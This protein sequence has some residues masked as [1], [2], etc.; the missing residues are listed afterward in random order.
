MSKNIG[1]FEILSELARSEFGCVYK[2]NDPD[3]GQ[4]VALKTIRLD[5]F[6]EHAQELVQRILKE[7][8]STKDLDCSNITLVYGAGEIDGQLCAT[9]DYIQGNS[10]ATMLARKEGFSIWDLLDISNQVCQGL[11]HAHQHTVFHYSL[12]PA[13]IMVT[14]DGTVKILSFGISSTGFMTAVAAGTPPSPLY[15]MSPEQV[16][17]ETMDPRSNLFTWGAMLYEMVTDQKAFDGADADEVRRKILEEMPPAPAD[18]NPKIN[19]IASEVIMKALA[20]DPAQRY[21]SGREM[22]NDLEKC[23][24]STGKAKK[25]ETPK[26][27]AAPDK[28]GAAA[29]AAKFAAPPAAPK[30]PA[31]PK[32]EPR[33]PEP[34]FSEPASSLSTELETSWTPPVPAANPAQR[35]ASLP[36]QAPAHKAT[37]AAAGWGSAGVSP[38]T[39]KAPYL[40][41]SSQFVTS[42]ARASVEALETQNASMSSAVLDEPAAEKRK[43]SVDPMMAEGVGAGSKGVSFSDLEELP[44]LKEIYV[45][46]PAPKAETPTEEEQLP[47]IILRGGEPEKPKIQ[48]REVAEKAL[49]EIKSLPP[50]LL[51]YSVAAAVVLILVIG[52]AVFWRAH[53][54]NTDEEGQVPAPVASSNQPAQ[55]AAPDQGSQVAASEA[56]P[57]ADTPEPTVQE[58]PAGRAAVA[59]VKPRNAKNRRTG[60]AAPVPG[61]LVVDSTP[62]GAQVQIDG[63]GDASWT[64]PYTVSAVA[65]GQHTIVVSKAGY[66]QET[67]T[68]DVTSA[69]RASLIVHLTALIATAAIAS[70]PAGASIYVDGKDTLRV[71]PYQITLEKGAHTVLVRKAGY[72]DETTSITAVPGQTTHYAATLRPL[73]NVDQIKTVGKLKKLFGGKVTE[74]GMGKVSVR[75]TPKGAQVSVNRRMLD[76]GAPVD[77][78]LNPGNYIIDITLTGYKPLQK[79]VVVDQGGS[80]SVD[81]TL[82]PE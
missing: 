53:S 5:A 71:T 15:Y 8:E 51:L 70:E 76:K 48:P 67:R 69:S 16:C 73:G 10:I 32:L 35:K 9:M 24:E 42:T 1:H 49:K 63:Q 22:A 77:F 20:K 60:A 29:A 23:R 57:Q 11:D 43:I 61:Q 56:A 66:G 62:Q 38:S 79:V 55:P 37:A 75:T 14:W 3:N 44:P 27:V 18:V 7:A 28:A 36:Q 64:T 80:V 30:A 59:T 81:E 52:I 12:E 82:Q 21:Q 50:Q 39:S 13:K 41:P 68:T 40:D 47:S 34:R 54:Q 6:G 4:T 2:A 72:L 46:P 33:A 78:M 17:G 19:S 45:A 26:A 25:A 31:V 58:R 65:P 74:P